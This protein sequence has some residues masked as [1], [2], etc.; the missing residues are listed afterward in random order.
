LE[1]GT[2]VAA[3]D[4][5]VAL[6]SLYFIKKKF[7]TKKPDLRHVISYVGISVLTLAIIFYLGQ[8]VT[9]LLN[10]VDSSHGGMLLL[11]GMTGILV[12]IYN[13]FQ[14]VQHGLSDR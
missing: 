3:A 14:L 8:L 4:L 9:K 5:L 1:S 2:L 11:A 12:I 13:A 10:A 7:S 6:A